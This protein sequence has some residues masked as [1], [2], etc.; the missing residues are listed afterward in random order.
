MQYSQ[1]S[2]CWLDNRSQWEGELQLLQIKVF[3]EKILN[4]QIRHIYTYPLYMQLMDSQNDL[5]YIHIYP[6]EILADI[7][8]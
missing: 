4:Y 1:D 5:G 3:V 7:W 2:H 8:H 6:C